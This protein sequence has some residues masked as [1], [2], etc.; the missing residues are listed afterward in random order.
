MLLWTWGYR[1]LFEVVFLFPSDIFSEVELLNHMVVLFLIFWGTSIP[2]STVAAT[3]LHS[4]Q[5]C[6][7]VFFSP[8]PCQ[9]LL[10]LVFL[11][12]AIVTGVRW[13]LIVVLICI[14]LM[15]SDIEHLFMYLLAIGISSLEKCAFRSFAHFWIGFF[16]FLLLS[17]MNSSYILD[18]NSLSYRWFANIFSHS[19]GCCFTLL[20]DSFAMQKLLNLV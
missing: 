7:K 13:Y 20:M 10:L 12:K 2:F 6:T 9:H 1:Y 19:V 4:H 16:V 11:I 5:Q 8:H 17:C 15:I 3:N 18:S 14:S